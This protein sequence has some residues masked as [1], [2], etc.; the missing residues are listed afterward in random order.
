MKAFGKW[1]GGLVAAVLAGVLVYWLTVGLSSPG[2]AGSLAGA[3]EPSTAAKT[4]TTGGPPT[5]TP[6]TGTPPTGTPPTGTPSTGTPSTTEAKVLTYWERL[7]GNWTLQYWNE[8]GGSTSLHIDVLRG[9]LAVGSDGQTSWRLDIQQ[10]AQPTSPQ[11]AIKCGGQVSLAGKI[12]GVPGD[13]L[14]ASIN[15]TS[16]LDAIDYGSA[17]D[18][19]IWRALCG[20]TV[21]GT[22]APFAITL[23]TQATQV[24]GQLEMSNQYGTF[25]WHRA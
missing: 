2:G 10:H 11:P 20:W 8:A 1:A 23:D 12:D 21:T 24:A 3:N 5:G 7:Q 15:W 9:T 6:P 18:G 16:G 14:N 19:Q 4:T 22:R 13:Q 17:G 25:S